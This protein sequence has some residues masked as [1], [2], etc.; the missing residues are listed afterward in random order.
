MME[1]TTP[2]TSAKW[3]PHSEC[4]LLRSSFTVLNALFQL[5]SPSRMQRVLTSKGLRRA[6][7]RGCRAHWFS[8]VSLGT[9]GANIILYRSYHAFAVRLLSLGLLCCALSSCLSQAT[10]SRCFSSYL[11]LPHTNTVAREL[12]RFQLR[13][14]LLT[15]NKEPKLRQA[16][17]FSVQQIIIVIQQHVLILIASA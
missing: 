7:T 9:C 15:V 1:E 6:T 14:W 5:L 2:R 16:E 17:L 12:V 13:L 8:L 4:S 3:R 10:R 11:V